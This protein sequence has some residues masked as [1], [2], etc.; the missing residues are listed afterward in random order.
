M[1]EPT[2]EFAWIASLRPLARGDPRALNLEDDAAIIPARP[3]WDLVI[4]KDAMVEGVHFLAAEDPEVVARRLVRTALSDLAA[5]AAEPFGYFLMTAWPAARD[6]TYRAGFLNGLALDGANFGLALLGGDTVATTGPVV[7]SATVLGWAP[8]GGTILRSGAKAG[9]RLVVC[10]YIGD[11]WLGLCAARENPVDSESALTRHYRLPIPLLSLR[12]VLA[13]HVRAAADVSDGLLADAIHIATAS[14]LGL[15]IDLDRLV[16][17]EGAR[18]WCENQS[19]RV[20]ARIALATGGD[21]YAIACAVAP[22]RVAPFLR[23]VTALGVPVG[24]VGEF[25]PSLGM[26]AVAGGRNLKL[27]D[28]GWRH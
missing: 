3:G 9:D 19:D 10:G 1:S 24:V 2:D 16:L 11:G 22:E 14:G 4:S 20:A 17:S 18:R 13:R 25:V 12:P 8:E 28:L 21:D 7:L 26:R 6:E 23:D 27:T 5:K 15:S